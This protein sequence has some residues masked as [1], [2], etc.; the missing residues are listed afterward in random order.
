MKKPLF[1]CLLA[2]MLAGAGSAL[3]QNSYDFQA[4]TTSYTPL[5]GSTAI[6][7]GDFN[8]NDLY[9]I[10]GLNGQT[11]YFFNTPF[12]MGGLKKFY[13]QSNGNLR[14]DNDS[15]IVIFDGAFMYLDSI[16]VNSSVSYKIDGTP[17]AYIFKGQWKNLKIREGQAVNFINFQ[18][19]VYQ[20]TG[21]VEIRYGQ[22]SS[23]NQSGYTNANG[24]QV[25]TFFSMVDFSQ[26]FEKIWVNGPP[27]T[28]R[29]DSAKNYVF[30]A[31]L[32]VPIE[33]T[34]FRFVPRFNTTGIMD[35][36]KGSGFRVYP[37]PVENILQ[38]PAKDDYF[39]YQVTGRLIETFNS[40]NAIDMSSFENGMYILKNSAGSAIRIIKNN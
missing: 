19:W 32:G 22:S 37:N 10:P 36:Q 5:S 9:T 13:I 30:R 7:W 4:T 25:G 24:P 39:L 11:F 38:L 18:I 17:G 28:I 35:I 2:S 15:A 21:V 33:G 31:M 26:C 14:I 3:S 1:V 23:N 40:S 16:D 27:T 12:P 8:A 6:P 20:Q 29:L 34:M